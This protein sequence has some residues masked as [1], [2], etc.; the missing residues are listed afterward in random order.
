MFNTH[1]YGGCLISE[2][3]PV[4]ID[5]RLEMYGDAFFSRYLAATGGDEKVLSKLLNH[6]RIA[7]TLLLPHDGAVAVLDR[8]P[9]WHRAYAD[10]QAVVHIRD[11]APRH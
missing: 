9:G 6:Y 7:W 1:R 3:V 8:L 2:G 5:G 11:N 4:F 10:A